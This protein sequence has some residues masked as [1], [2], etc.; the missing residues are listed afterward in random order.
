MH[1]DKKVLLK[2]ILGN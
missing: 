1:A 2:A